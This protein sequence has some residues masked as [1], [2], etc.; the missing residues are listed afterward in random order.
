MSLV[1]NTAV[2]LKF[3]NSKAQFISIR[4]NF[5]VT[6]AID[7]TTRSVDHLSSGHAHAIVCGLPVTFGVPVKSHSEAHTWRI[8]VNLPTMELNARRAKI[9]DSIRQQL[10]VMYGIR[11]Y[12]IDGR[13][14]GNF[15][16]SDTQFPL[17]PFNF[18]VQGGRPARA[19]FTVYRQNH[20]KWVVPFHF[21][22]VIV[23]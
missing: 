16:A 1:F 7:P 18:R 11:F 13:S 3:P 4:G 6:M 15:F 17:G 2:D 10:A 22:H 20:V 19:V 12:G 23:P 8:R 21:N 5:L 9:A 14:L